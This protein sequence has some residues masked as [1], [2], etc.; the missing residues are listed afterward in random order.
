MYKHKSGVR[1]RKL[2]R[3]DLGALLCMK[4]STWW[5][6]HKTLII[7]QEDQQRWYDNLPAN[8]LFLIGEHEDAPVVLV[9]CTNIDHISRS[10]SISGSLFNS[11]PKDIDIRRGA[12]AAG[13]DFAFEMLNMR[14]IEAEV[15]AHNRAAQILE[16]QYLGFRIEGIK[17]AA[18]YKCGIYLDSI[19]L[20]L[21]REEWECHERVRAMGSSCNENFDVEKAQRNIEKSCARLNLD[22]FQEELVWEEGPPWSTF[23]EATGQH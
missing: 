22:E 16:I 5:G 2:E 7:A 20:G 8:Q 17:R 3:K 4:H 15:L 18:V 23:I 10:L 6:T 12:F 9:G 14:R 11:C 1:L 13:L 19:I 21:L